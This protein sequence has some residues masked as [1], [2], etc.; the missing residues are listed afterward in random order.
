MVFNVKYSGSEH[1]KLDAHEPS[2]VTSSVAFFILEVGGGIF[3]QFS[4]C[5]LLK[6]VKDNNP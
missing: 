4:K 5:F 2:R 6:I 1:S 3:K